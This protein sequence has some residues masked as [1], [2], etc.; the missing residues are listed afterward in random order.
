MDGL[1]VVGEALSE[2]EIQR[3]LGGVEAV[4]DVSPSGKLA[5]TWARIKKADRRGRACSIPDA[6]SPTLEL[7]F[8]DNGNAM[9][10]FIK[11][12]LVAGDGEL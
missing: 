12:A 7:H 4:L 3:G 2:K 6:A 1:I 5:T 10:G 8:H 11:Y 9:E